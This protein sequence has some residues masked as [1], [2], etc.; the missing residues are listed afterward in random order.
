MAAYFKAINDQGGVN[1]RKTNFIACDDAYDPAKLAENARKLNE[2]DKVFSFT[3]LGGTNIGLRDYTNRAKLPQ[4]FI[5]A[6]NTPLGEVEKYPVYTRLVA[7]H[8][9]RRRDQWA[10]VT[11]VLTQGGNQTINA[12]KFMNQIGWTPRFSCMEPEPAQINPH[13]HRTGPEQ[14]AVRGVVVEGPP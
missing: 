11:T 8:L 14:G 12:V 1:G 7:G 9:R 6:S 3:G 4:V 13:R 2:Q 10:G 5:M